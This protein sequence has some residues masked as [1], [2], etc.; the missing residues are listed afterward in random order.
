MASC[1]TSDYR[2]SETSRDLVGIVAEPDGAD[3]VYR[4][5]RSLYVGR[6]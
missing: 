3:G 2:R 5:S 1:Q 6:A 4:V